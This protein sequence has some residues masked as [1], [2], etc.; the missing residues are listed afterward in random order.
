VEDLVDREFW[1]H[2]SVLVTGA[3]GFLG[4]WLAER[5]VGL[6]ANVVAIVRDFVPTSRLFE[7]KTSSRMSLVSG[8][9]KDRELIER[10][11][12]EYEVDTVFHLAAQ[13]IVQIANANPISTFESNIAG[14]WNVLEAARRSPRVKRVVIASSDKAYGTHAELPYTEE[15]SL[16]G[17]HPYDVS[18]SCADLIARSYWVTYKLPVTV[19]RCANLYGGGDLNWNRLVPG[20][21]RDAL[22][23]RRPVLRSDGTMVR[24]YLYVEHAVD[25]Y[26]LTARAMDDARHHGE[27]FNFSTNNQLTALQLTRKILELMGS[28]LTP[29]VRGHATHEI[30]HQY[31]S[32]EKAQTVLGWRPPAN[33]DEGLLRTIAWYR[34]F[35][36]RSTPAET[37]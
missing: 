1:R 37:P 4:S 17:E 34:R 21:I 5:L 23:G 6:D 27:A 11:L 36:S 31:L 3:T 8:D 20:V 22:S 2:R 19:T 26:L 29:D 25:A 10:V 7:G 30:D 18:K 35:L 16:R 24:D 32:A 15:M 12:G 9:V 14:T 13:T 28:D 33:V